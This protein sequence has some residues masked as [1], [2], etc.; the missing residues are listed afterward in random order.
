MSI[1]K[2]NSNTWLIYSFLFN[3]SGNCHGS[4]L[5]CEICLASADQVITSGGFEWL[6]LFKCF[7]QD[8]HGRQVRVNYATDRARPS[9]GGGGGGYGNYGYQGGNYSGGGGYGGGGGGGDGYGS[10]GG[11]FGGGGGGGNYGGS[12]GYASGNTYDG[13]NSGN[14]GGGSDNFN[15]ASGG[16]GNDNNYFG[17]AAGGT[18][19][20][21]GAGYDVSTEG[22]GNSGG[23][24]FGTIESS[25]VG[26]GNLGDPSEGNYRD[27]DDEP[28]DYAKRAW[29]TPAEGRLAQVDWELDAK[30]RKQLN[31]LVLQF[32][33]RS[34]Q[35]YSFYFL[36]PLLCLK[37][38]YFINVGFGLVKLTSIKLLC[39]IKWE[40]K[41]LCWENNL[42]WQNYFIRMEVYFLCFICGKQSWFA[43][44]TI[45]A[46]KG[47]EWVCRL[48]NQ[49]GTM[50][51]DLLH[52]TLLLEWLVLE[53]NLTRLSFSLY[54]IIAFVLVCWKYCCFFEV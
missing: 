22:P 44:K 54:E 35:L 48:F 38:V 47:F 23:D 27:D 51:S 53:S 49:R 14:Y 30:C 7:F 11:G 6:F 36:A 24:Q 9:Y 32:I 13:G 45:N 10:R 40:T 4:Y 41:R 33:S 21:G 50:V 17:G 20:F 29:K 37:T 42:G 26:E 18:S 34:F 12:G 8:L 52:G 5:L 19:N 31:L 1:R 28:D 43:W 16:S 15:V 2:P 39:L 25:S 46:V 3:T